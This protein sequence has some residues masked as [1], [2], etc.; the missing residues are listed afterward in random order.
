MRVSCPRLFLQLILHYLAKGETP[1]ESTRPLG[2]Y[3]AVLTECETSVT[4]Q[5]SHCVKKNY[6]LNVTKREFAFG[7]ETV[8]N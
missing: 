5:E 8:L 4:N 1:P 6:L 7:E 2:N 3:T